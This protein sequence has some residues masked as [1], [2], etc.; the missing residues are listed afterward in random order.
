[1]RNDDYYYE[2]LARIEFRKRDGDRRAEWARRTMG[3]RANAATPNEPPAVRTVLRLDDVGHAVAER[4]I[5]RRYGDTEELRH[6]Q[7]Y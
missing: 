4:S 3:M 6:P 1:M 2:K 7:R 5:A